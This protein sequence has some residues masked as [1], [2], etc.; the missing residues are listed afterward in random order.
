MSNITN[1][2]LISNLPK[3]EKPAYSIYFKPTK[4]IL[5]CFIVGIIMFIFD[6]IPLIGILISIFSALIFFITP[7]YLIF[8]AYKTFFVI[9]NKNDK[10]NCQLIYWND[11][12]E[13]A[14]K[15]G[16]NGMDSLIIKTN[17]NNIHVINLYSPAKIIHCFN[18]FVSEKESYNVQKNSIKNTPFILPWQKKRKDK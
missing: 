9:Y 12:K 16:N 7:N 14:Y 10:I 6:F 8:Q 2:F 17:D 11:V 15:S 3:N 18:K 13:W 5:I 1:N 4:S